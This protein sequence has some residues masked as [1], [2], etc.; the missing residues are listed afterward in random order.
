MSKRKSQVGSGLIVQLTSATDLA[1]MDSN[2]LSDPYAVISCSF[3]QQKFKSKCI[4]KT[5]NPKWNETF[6]FL[7][8]SPSGTINIKLMDRD[9]FWS[10]DDFLGEVIIPVAPLLDGTPMTSTFPVTNEPQVGKK[11]GQKQGQLTLTLHYPDGQL[12]SKPKEVAPKV[13]AVP[14]E[15]SSKK[16]TVHDL[17]TFGKVLGTGGFSVVKEGIHK[18]SGV[19]YAI[20][21]IQK[22]SAGADDIALLY[23]EIDIMIKFR[24]PN[25]ISLHDVFEDDKTLYLILELV[26]GGELFDQ[27]VGRGTYSEFEA[28]AI[29][30][31][32]LDAV[33]YMHSNGIAHRDLKPENLLCAGP[34]SSIIKVTDFG[35]SKDFGRASMKTSCGTPDYVA[36]EVLRGQKYDNTVDLW[37]IGVITYILVCGFPPF[38]GS[39]EQQVFAKILKCEFSFPAP[40]WTDKSSDVKEFISSILVLDV[41]ARPTA[42][43]ALSAP[44]ILSPPKKK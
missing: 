29:V 34:D 38:Y 23:S 13:A 30:K 20:K 26:T 22:E 17:Y 1:S 6:T 9:P 19:G 24:H 11:K 16:K 41:N 40:D 44:W 2:G 33:H 36:P 7:A 15:L 32:I 10:K 3:N 21:I 4:K 35:L 12:Q 28:S 27:I 5:L 25:I 39:D 14:K 18:E 42:E 43:Q 8:A 37:S 31:Q